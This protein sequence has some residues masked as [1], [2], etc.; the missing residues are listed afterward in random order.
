MVNTV[1]ILEL[2]A[3]TTLNSTYG[4]SWYFKKSNFRFCPVLSLYVKKNYLL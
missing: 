2:K 1:D 3:I 4:S